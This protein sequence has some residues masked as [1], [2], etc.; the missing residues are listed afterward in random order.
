MKATEEEL[1]ELKEQLRIQEERIIEQEHRFLKVLHNFFIKRKEWPKGDHRRKAA[2]KALLYAVFFSP[3]TIATTGSIIAIATLITLMVQTETMVEQTEKLEAQNN[4]IIQQ[5]LLLQA[6]NEQQEKQYAYERITELT[7]I[8]YDTATTANTTRLK[9]EAI[10]EFILLKKK[11][12]P[13]EY[14]NLQRANLT[15]III[16]NQS[17]K[18]INMDS[19]LFDG[20]NFKYAQ[21]TN[22]SMKHC[23]FKNTIF[24]KAHVDSVSFDHSHFEA[25]KFDP[26]DKKHIISDYGVHDINEILLEFGYPTQLKNSSFNHCEFKYTD[27]TGVF[28]DSCDFSLTEF[29]SIGGTDISDAYIRNCLLTSKQIHSFSGIPNEF[30]MTDCSARNEFITF[31]L[32]SFNLKFLKDTVY[33]YNSGTFSSKEL[34]NIFTCSDDF[35]EVD[36][37]AVIQDTN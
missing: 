6:Q 27:L 17:S 2:T 29:Y 8:L 20:A 4:G 35:P 30:Y 33:R 31:C 7:E 28:L 10:V 18:K 21:L 34:K 37:N 36:K 9:S 25:T 22:V 26:L 24:S 13:K 32:D 14:V 3:T 15:G 19:V 23:S 11:L 5:N 16:D 1:K 12:F